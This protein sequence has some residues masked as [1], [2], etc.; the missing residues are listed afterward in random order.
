[1]DAWEAA[2]P[3]TIIPCGRV[4]ALW[5]RICRRFNGKA[6]QG[7]NINL[8]FYFYFFFFSVDLSPPGPPR[9]PHMGA[10]DRPNGR[11]QTIRGQS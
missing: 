2:K 1:M 9:P 7:H 8:L 4:E 10:V 11:G 3:K 5:S 6:G